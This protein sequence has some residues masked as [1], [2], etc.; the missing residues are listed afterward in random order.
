MISFFSFEHGKMGKIEQEA[1]LVFKVAKDGANCV[2]IFNRIAL[3]PFSVVI[4]LVS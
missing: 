4:E 1:S 3:F 2:A